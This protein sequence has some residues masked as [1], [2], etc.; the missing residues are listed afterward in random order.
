MLKRV[1]VA[2]RGEIALRVVRECLDQGIEAVAVYS[3]ADEHSLH[4]MTAD[5]AVCIG[6]A[7]PQKSYLNMANIIEAALGTDCDAIH[8]GFGFLSE[9][10]KFAQLCEENGIKFIGPKAS[11]IE[12]MGNKAAARRMMQSANV[13]VV[14][15]S[16][17]VVESVRQAVEIAGKIGYPVLVKA[18]AGGGGKGMRRAANEEELVRAFEQARL[19]AEAAFGDS[20]VYIEKLIVNPRHIE[21]QVLADSYGNVI[22]LGERNCSIQRRNQKMIEEAPA[23]ALHE[24]TRNALCEAA[25]RA[26][27]ISNYEGAGTV[28]FVLDGDDNFYFIEMNTRIQVEHPVT[29]MITGVNIVA[30]Q[31]RIASA[32]PLRYTQD[33]IKFTGY[34]IECRVCCED[35]LNDFAPCPG[36]V[37]F[38]HFPAGF[39]VRTDSALYSGAEISPY[40]DS[41]AAKIIVWGATRLQAVRKMRRALSETIVRGPKTTLQLAHLIM[42]NRRFL[43]GKYNT[44]FIENELEKLLHILQTA[45]NISK[46]KQRGIDYESISGKEKHIGNDAGLGENERTDREDSTQ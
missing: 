27:K 32:L 37:D 11:V 12:L 17:G 46:R 21:V 20:S 9:N 39:G 16:D 15:G 43:R 38:V 42:Y 34:A 24:E 33:D 41:M 44:S 28:E 10:P 22:H 1:L 5:K 25:V 30:Q 4:V 6:E 29:E 3:V 26:A 13:P 7:S 31:L 18:S 2:N 8:P 14:P 36:K 19:E 40:Y 35:P 45:Q 23:W